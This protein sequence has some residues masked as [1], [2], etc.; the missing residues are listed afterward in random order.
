MDHDAQPKLALLLAAAAVL[1]GGCAT[2][3]GPAEVRQAF[4][5]SEADGI[6][7]SLALDREETVIGAPV[8]AI[9]TVR[10]VGPRTIRW[11]AGGCALQSTVS[12]TAARPDVDIVAPAPVPAPVEAAFLAAVATAPGAP[13]AVATLQSTPSGAG[14]GCQIDHGFAELAPGVRLEERAVWSALTIAG[15]PAVPGDYIVRAAFPRLRDDA[16][17]VPANF[18]ADR[19]V[20]PV[21]VDLTIR[22][23]DVGR[24]TV[25]A[26]AA[27]LALIRGTELG[28]L[29][30]SGGVK[31][32]DAVLSWDDQGWILHV[33]L[34]DGGSA[35]GR[36]AGTA[37]A[38]ATLERVR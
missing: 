1:A 29:V 30:R 7:I 14:R 27:V 13:A 2:E 15:G 6:T 4:A 3:P 12:V 19:D 38:R 25:S 5:S 26:G 17:L 33:R 18:Q 37:P 23:R 9:V 20:Q 22:V 11:R 21:R 35:V 16:A 36:V 28:D 10:N 32:A 24:P 8:E 34:P 31:P